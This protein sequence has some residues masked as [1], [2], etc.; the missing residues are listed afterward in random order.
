M[1]QG[2]A[3]G[4]CQPLHGGQVHNDGGAL[5]PGG[6]LLLHLRYIISHPAI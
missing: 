4:G 3:G 6:R 1:L 5:L 2:G